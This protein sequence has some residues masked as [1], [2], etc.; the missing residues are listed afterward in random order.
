MYPLFA[1]N[2]QVSEPRNQLVHPAVV[3]PEVVATAPN[4]LQGPQKH[5]MY[6]L[7][8][9]L[10]VHSHYVPGWLLAEHPLRQLT[11]HADRGS[12]MTSKSLALVLADL[13]VV[14]SHSRTR[15]SND[16]LYS[17]AQLKTMKYRPDYLE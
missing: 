11:L 14:K 12:A 6:H 3:K 9:V 4:Q 15:F 2:Q 8:V 5:R 17:E 16:Y 13:G 1:I 7:Y 10:D